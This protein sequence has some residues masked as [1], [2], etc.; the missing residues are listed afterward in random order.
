MAPIRVL[1]LCHRNSG[2][3]L[4]AEAYLRR[5]GR[6]LFEA[7]SAAF[8][9][10]EPG[11]LVI[12]VMREANFDLAARPAADA[13]ELIR[14]RPSYHHVIT[15]CAPEIFGDVPAFPGETGRH[16][17]GFPDPALV[18]GLREEQLAA[19]RTIRDDIRAQVIRFV[20]ELTL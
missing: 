13:R 7:H 17:W 1:F 5:L 9:A 20:H 12:E 10:A 2:R 4:M 3:T 19:A 6:G 16:H 18:T 14:K 11:P 8:S 15:T